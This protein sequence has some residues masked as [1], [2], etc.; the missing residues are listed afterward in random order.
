MH[1]EVQSWLEEVREESGIQWE[2]RKS[3][4]RE[5]PDQYG[6][7]LKAF[8]DEKEYYCTGWGLLLTGTDPYGREATAVKMLKHLEQPEYGG[9]EPV[10]LDAMELG[11]DPI[12]RLN[13]L[14][15]AYYDRKTGLCLV[16]EKLEGAACRWEVLR[17]LGRQLR[18]YYLYP[19]E[20]TPLFLILMDDLEQEI[21]DLLRSR[22]RLCR[23]NIPDQDLTDP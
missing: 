22:L 14:L 18:A 13:V 4:M 11:D 7:I 12:G 10:F 23:T 9:Y 19:E 8:L 20:Y 21:P 3:I 17:F 15:D 16:L 6:G 5:D 2:Y 1:K